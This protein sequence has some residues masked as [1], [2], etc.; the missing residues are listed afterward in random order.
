[1]LLVKVRPGE[2]LQIDGGISLY[3]DE[4]E[5]LMIDAPDGVPISLSPDV[6][7]I[8][9]IDVRI[10]GRWKLGINAPPHLG[11]VRSNAIRRTA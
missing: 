9:E 2:T 8:A 10:I 7:R 1:M 3:F 11:I 5:R 6:A 4:A